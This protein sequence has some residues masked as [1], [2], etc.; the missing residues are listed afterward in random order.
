MLNTLYEIQKHIGMKSKG[1]IQKGAVTFGVY[2]CLQ[3]VPVTSGMDKSEKMTPL[4]EENVMVPLDEVYHNKLDVLT[5]NLHPP[6][7]TPTNPAGEYYSVWNSDYVH[8]Y[9]SNLLTTNDT[10]RL[11]LNDIYRCNYVHPVNSDVNSG[12]GYRKGRYHFGVDL[13][14]EYGEPIYNSFDGKV[15]VAKYSP[16]YGNVVVVRHYNGLETV[17][18]H[19]SDFSVDKGDEI[20][21]GTTV[22]LGGNT[23]RSTGTHLHYEVRFQGEPVDPA[24]VISFEHQTLKDD[25]LEV[26]RS[27]S[28]HLAIQNDKKDT[29]S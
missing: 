21:A 11:V 20:R 16:T 5:I 2:V 3:A 22:G 26:Y 6:K 19:L 13:D 9:A 17:Y 23:G 12:F 29:S 28:Q 27:N 18:S 4:L 14:I 10:V 1:F 25:T 15:R 24:E 8:P 7:E